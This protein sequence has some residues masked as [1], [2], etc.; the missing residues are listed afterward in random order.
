MT[1]EQAYMIFVQKVNENITNGGL[2]ADKSRFVL[3]FNSAQIRYAHVLTKKK[4]SND[5]VRD[6]ELLQILGKELK[7]KGLLKD[8]YQFKLPDNYFEF[9][10]VSVYASQGNCSG[11]KM[12]AWEIK[13]E[14]KSEILFD[15]N[16]KPSFKYQEVPYLIANGNINIYVDT[17]DMF[18]I[19]QVILDYYRYPRP[20]GMR[21][22]IGDKGIELK[23]VDPEFDDKVVLQII[24][25][26]VT[27]FDLAKNDLNKVPADI[28][29][30]QITY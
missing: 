5:E 10:D 25:M 29:R 23:N 12:L 8:F 20:I 1:V 26:A 6:V 21:G 22:V 27:D 7:S 15:E 13:G 14:N 4:K 19:N 17:K 28:N 2:A 11:M 30:T 24:N 16:N 9:I 3:L 18:T